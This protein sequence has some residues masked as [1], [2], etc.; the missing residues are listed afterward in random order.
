MECL[1]EMLRGAVLAQKFVL[2]AEVQAAGQVLNFTDQ[3]LLFFHLIM[4]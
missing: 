3:L 2:P 4:R 1:L